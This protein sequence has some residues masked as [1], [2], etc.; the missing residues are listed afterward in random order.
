MKTGDDMAWAG[1]DVDASDWKPVKVGIPW[2]EVGFED[3]D[4]YAWYRLEFVIPQTSRDQIEQ[5]AKD[6]PFGPYLILSMGAVDDVDETFFNG[7]M[8]FL[9]VK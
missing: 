7:K 4:G 2:E 6:N 5:H 1:M 3:Y 9:T 8:H